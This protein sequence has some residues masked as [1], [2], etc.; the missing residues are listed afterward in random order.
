[1]HRSSSI[2]PAT[3]VCMDVTRSDEA[4]I[5]ALAILTDEELV[6]RCALVALPR[7]A[8]QGQII[9]R[10]SENC[11]IGILARAT[12]RSYEEFKVAA[13]IPLEWKKNPLEHFVHSICS[14]H[15]PKNSPE[16]AHLVMWC[17]EAMQNRTG[18]SVSM[19][20]AGEPTEFHMIGQDNR[21]NAFGYEIPLAVH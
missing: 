7:A 4:K 1:M 12:G 6:S 19:T 13:G 18:A 11:V 16:C 5:Q 21:G 14:G 3:E 10:D 15:T 9:G 8:E 20:H 2:N 17:D